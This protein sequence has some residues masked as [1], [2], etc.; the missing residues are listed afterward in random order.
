M[1]V[2][3]SQK[4]IVQE[5]KKHRSRKLIFTNGCFDI[6]HIGHIHL[7]KRCRELG[8]VVI[9]GLN[10][11]NSVFRLKGTGHPVMPQN[12]RA[13][14]LTSLSMVDFVVIFEEDDPLNLI[15]LI[16]PDILVK[17]GDYTMD[18]V[19]G[20]KEI[21]SWGGRVELFPYIKGVSTSDIISRIK[22]IP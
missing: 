20:R 4:D 13:E 10:S 19:V 2:L 11:D 8:D 15:K 17:G 14:I 9:V 16:R 5:L 3:V 7:L 6:L 18:E 21:E 22:S 12:E 1:G